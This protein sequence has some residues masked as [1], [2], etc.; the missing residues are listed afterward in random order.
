MIS[1]VLEKE[2]TKYDPVKNGSENE[3]KAIRKYDIIVFGASGF[4]GK[5]VAMEMAN[6]SRT[7]SLSWAVAGRNL[8]KLQMVLNDIYK[9]LSKFRLGMNCY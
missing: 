2:T 7:Y 3:M 5:Y 6:I 1:Q 4:T 9:T 8:N